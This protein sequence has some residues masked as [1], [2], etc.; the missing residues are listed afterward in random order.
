[1]NSRVCVD[2]NIIVWALVPTSASRK[3]ET[4]LQTWQETDTVLIAPALLAYEVTSAL[5]RLVYLKEIRPET[6]EIAFARFS[7]IDIHLLSRADIFQRAWELAKELNQSRAYDAA[8]LAVA[9]LNQCDLW[10]ADERLYN[11]VQPRIPWVK[12]LGNFEQG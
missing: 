3:A 1:M 4:L 12:W 8:Y 2:A 7:R 9:Q 5:R 11:A 10:T 6:G